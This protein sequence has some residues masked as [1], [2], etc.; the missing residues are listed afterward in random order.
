MTMTKAADIT[1]N[2]PR[3]QR[4]R[5]DPQSGYTHRVGG[6]VAPAEWA[7]LAPRAT[8]WGISAA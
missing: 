3:I 7:Q 1:V 4:F 5:G 2:S 8:C 6:Q